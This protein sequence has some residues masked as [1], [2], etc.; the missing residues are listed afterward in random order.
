MQRRLQEERGVTVREVEGAEEGHVGGAAKHVI[1]RNTH[2]GKQ[3]SY[4]R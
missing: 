1:Y 4:D 3:S 2:P